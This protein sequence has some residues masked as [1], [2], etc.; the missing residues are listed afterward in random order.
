MARQI[1]QAP[2][3]QYFIRV[4]SDRPF[5]ELKGDPGWGE[6]VS[7]LAGLGLEAPRRRDPRPEM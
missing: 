1:F 4:T 6:L 3:E 5:E 2:A 7:A